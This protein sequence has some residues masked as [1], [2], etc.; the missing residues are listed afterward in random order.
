MFG[1]PLK[2]FHRI[3][4]MCEAVAHLNRL[5]GAGRLARDLGAD[6]VARFVAA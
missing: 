6:G 3:L 5:L 2:G 1:R 4:A